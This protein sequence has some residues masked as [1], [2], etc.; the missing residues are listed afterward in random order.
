MY[1]LDVRHTLA[2]IGDEIHVNSGVI[3]NNNNHN[4]NHNNHNNHNNNHNNNRVCTSR[5]WMTERGRIEVE[6]GV[7]MRAFHWT[8]KSLPRITSQ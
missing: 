3:I 1:L 8:H 4:N 5:R 7:P 6:V 2:C